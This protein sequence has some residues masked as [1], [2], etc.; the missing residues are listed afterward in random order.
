MAKSL[1]PN[2]EYARVISF[3][4]KNSVSKDFDKFEEIAANK[5]DITRTSAL[6]LLVQEFLENQELQKRIMHKAKEL[7]LKK[8]W[9]KRE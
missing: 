1:G 3:S 5:L 4:I 9:R 6:I 8:D 2:E 7:N